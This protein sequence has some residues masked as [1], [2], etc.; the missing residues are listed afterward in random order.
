MQTPLEKYFALR[1]KNLFNHLHDFELNGDEG[2]MHDLR[3][4]IKKMRAVLKFLRTIYPKQQL[5]KPS[6][7]LRYIFQTA[8]AIREL[9]L[10]QI[11]LR[12]SQ[13]EVILST[14]YSDQKLAFMIDQFR[15]NSM[16]YKEDFK[17]IITSC[18][19]YI[20][21]TNEI[22]AEQYFVDLNA[23]VE[24]YCRRNLPIT[25]WH[26]LRK[27]IKQRLYSYNWVTHESDN[28]DPNFAYFH[29]LQES[30]GLWHDLEIIKESF[31]QKQVWLSQNIEVQKE[32][33]AAWEKLE[34]SIKQKEKQVEDLLAKQLLT[35]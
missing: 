8:G 1:T 35:D 13:H 14:Y 33:A 23:Q 31:S 4:E 19:E 3:V 9:Q 16:Q 7:L 24:K 27:L 25:E 29:K 6:H 21:S 5:K 10:L 26:N 20:R 12:K 30:I 15:I 18:E 28:D 34:S 11:W 2:S 17:D 22:L 32:F